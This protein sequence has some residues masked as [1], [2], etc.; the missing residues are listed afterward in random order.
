MTRTQMAWV[1]A[2]LIVGFAAAPGAQQRQVI[3]QG[4][5]VD[6]R[7]EGG[8]IPPELAAM[9]G[10]GT[11]PMGVGSGIIV[12]QAYE[13]TSGQPIPGALVTLSLP[14]VAPLRVMADG[15]GR[16]A[17]RMLPAGAFSLSASKPGFVDGAY[18]QRRPSGPTHPV[19]LNEAGRMTDAD[20]PLWRYSAITGTVTD[21]RG[22]PVVG[23]TVQALIRTTVAGMPK[24]N[25]GPTDETDDRG[26]YRIGRLAPGD[27]VVALPAGRAGDQFVMLSGGGGNVI[28]AATTFTAATNAVVREGPGGA[29]L[30]DEPEEL[31]GPAGAAPDGTPLTY[32]TL[33]YPSSPVASQAAVVRLGSGEE[34]GSIDF[35]R[36][37]LPSSRVTGTLMGPDGPAP[38]YTVTLTPAGSEDLV[39][40]V[41]AYR[42]ETRPDGQFVFNH[43]APGQYTLRVAEAP[44]IRLG[45]GMEETVTTGGGGMFVM[46]TAITVGRGGAEPP[47]PEEPT[48]WAER[49]ISVDR[50]VDVPIVLSAGVRISGQVAFSG[51]AKR[52]DDETLPSMRVTLDPADG[53]TSALQLTLRGRIET[54]GLFRT[55]SVPPGQYFVRVD[56]VPQG[57]YFRGAT[58]GGRDVSDSP[59]V[60]E[61]EDITGV[62]LSFTDQVTEISG[63]VTNDSDKEDSTALVIAFP[64][65][66]SGWINYGSRPR[67]LT[68]TRATDTGSFR[69]GGLPPGE[70]F[71]AAVRDEIAGD[72]QRTDFLDAVAAAATRVRLGDGDKQNVSLRVVR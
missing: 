10:R 49:T 68:S 2:A 30:L 47:L 38:N 42:A 5:N 57:W 32:Q 59:L 29:R 14:G 56:R 52:P 19:V 12:G 1:A 60:V 71:V 34:R 67:R 33:F 40:P 41:G 72:W 8:D 13:P 11:T 37:P 26:V 45:G 44:R 61:G 50:E 55:M 18:G 17:F 48:L 53:R 31:V 58:L 15:Q 21:E 63:S 25:P 66:R 3:M 54:S 62:T 16:F 70:Y 46:R 69:I 28:Q 43:V 20:V 9:L 65:D 35:V 24:L 7:I 27:Y 22:E 39:A 51:A 6:I 64:T 4:G 23:A 36:E